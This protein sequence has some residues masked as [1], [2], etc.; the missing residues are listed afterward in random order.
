MA[1]GLP[2]G[3]WIL[4]LASTLPGL[5]LVALVYVIH[6]G[7]GGKTGRSGSGAAGRSGPEGRFGG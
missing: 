4:I 2:L 3:T 1:L 7:G 5:V 6:R